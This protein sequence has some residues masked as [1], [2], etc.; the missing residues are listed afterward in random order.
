MLAFSHEYDAVHDKFRR[1]P[2][3]M[4][5][6]KASRVVING[7]LSRG[8]IRKFGE[9]FRG[10]CNIT[11][12]CDEATI[13]GTGRCFHLEIRTKIDPGT[14]DLLL[15]WRGVRLLENDQVPDSSIR[16]HKD[17]C[18]AHDVLLQTGVWEY[19]EAGT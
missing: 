16:G 5:R 10:P 1:W 15:N 8:E 18:D 11:Q 14:G 17:L 19:I 13:N 7:N 9:G 12:D 3:E 6:S 4:P 2:I